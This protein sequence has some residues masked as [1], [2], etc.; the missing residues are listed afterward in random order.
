[1]RAL[2]N[3]V[4]SQEKI[5]KDWRLPRNKAAAK[6]PGVTRTEDAVDVAGWHGVAISR[7]DKRASMATEWVFD[8]RDLT[9]LGDRTY[10]AKDTRMGKKGMV[11]SE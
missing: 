7:V 2:L 9:Y 1:M 5:R 3:S 11:M 4:Q 8:R 10:L 6:I